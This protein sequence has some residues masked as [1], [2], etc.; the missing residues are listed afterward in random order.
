VF[1]ADVSVAV[2]S[3]DRTRLHGGNVDDRKTRPAVMTL[4][5][6]AAAFAARV[7]VDRARLPATTSMIAKR[8]L[9]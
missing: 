7:P 9:P 8:S 1:A 3:I 4:N 5:V 6:S 2:H